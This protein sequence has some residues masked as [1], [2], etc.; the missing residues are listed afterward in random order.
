MNQTIEER[1]NVRDFTIFAHQ[2]GQVQ[3]ATFWRK[4]FEEAMS[5]LRPALEREKLNCIE[6]S[7]LRQALSEAQADADKW[8][9]RCEEIQ[10]TTL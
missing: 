10:N 7:A 5:W 1:R 8:R 6:I 3:G 2:R 4:K 9:K